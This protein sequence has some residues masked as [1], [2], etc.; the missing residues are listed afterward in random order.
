MGE[1]GRNK[2]ISNYIN[3]S[4]GGKRGGGREEGKSNKQPPV[5]NEKGGKDALYQT[6]KGE[7]KKGSKK[8]GRK[9]GSRPPHSSDKQKIGGT[10]L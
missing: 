5:I 9:G 4:E 8:G 1:E 10:S 6:Q 7:K 3:M 2:T